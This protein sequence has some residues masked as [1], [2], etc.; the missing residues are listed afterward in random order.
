MSNILII[1]NWQQ[2]VK[3]RSENYSNLRITV[4]E[5][6]SADLT[7]TQISIV[8]YDTNTVYFRSFVNVTEATLIPDTAK[9]STQDMIT[10]INN[11]GFNVKISEPEVVEQNVI[12][13]LQGLYASGYRYIYK[14]YPKPYKCKCDTNDKFYR[15]YA[16]D[17]IQLRRTDLDVSNM[18]G[19]IDDQWDWCLPFTTYPISDILENGTV[20]NGS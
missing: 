3:A 19:F 13:I 9:L 16:S 11:Y 17:V 5:Y 10:T 1:S 7:G 20:N 2:L 12:T 18:P 6:N 4:S 14:D 15:I 8:D